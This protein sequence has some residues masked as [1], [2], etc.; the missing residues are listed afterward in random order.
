MLREII[1]E[2]LSGAGH[3]VEVVEEAE[4]ILSAIVRVC[5]ALLLLD[6]EAHLPGGPGHLRCIRAAHPH[7]PVVVTASRVGTD[8]R[9]DL[10]ASTP[11]VDGVLLKPFG[12]GD[13]P[14]LVGQL[15][16]QE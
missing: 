10:D 3:L 6:L 14:A 7:L 13:L 11:G 16:P 1:A 12:R 15:C 4:E 2:T 8:W 5:P 9:H